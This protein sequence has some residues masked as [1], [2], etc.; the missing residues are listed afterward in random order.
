MA[1]LG[2]LSPV[3]EAAPVAPGSAGLL[4]ATSTVGHVFQGPGEADSAAGT[5]KAAI[6]RLQVSALLFC[7]GRNDGVDHD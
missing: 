6:R 2:R 4:S 3:A 5:R 1:P 7:P